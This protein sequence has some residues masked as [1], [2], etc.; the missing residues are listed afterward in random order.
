MNDRVEQK[1]IDLYISNVDRIGEGMPMWF[2]GRRREWIDN[3]SLCALPDKR[4]ERYRLNDMKELF[5]ADWSCIF[6]ADQARS[7]ALDAME[8][9]PAQEL[10]IDGYKVDVNNGSVNGSTLEVLENGVIYG[11]LAVAAVDFEQIVKKYYNSIADNKADAVT[12]LNSSFM[13][14]GVFVYVPENVKAELPFVLNYY[15]GT[16]SEKLLNF[17]RTLIVLERGASAEIVV[18]QQ[19]CSSE[20]MLVDYVREIELGEGASLKLSEYCTM[21]ETS[22]IVL[23]SYTRQATNSASQGVL[24]MLG[25][26]LSR[27]NYTV[28]LL[29]AGADAKMY[30]LYLITDEQRA[31]I[32]VD[33]NHLVADCTSY[34][35]VKGVAA[36]HAVGSFTGRVY[37]APNAQRTE[38]FQQSRNLLLNDT[39]RIYTKPQLEIYADDVKCSHGATVGQLDAEAIYYMR[40]RGISEADARKLQMSGFVNDIIAHSP[41]ERLA[42]TVYN[43]VATKIDSL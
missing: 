14:D 38:A 22:N 2:N 8:S 20:N 40:Q 29:G 24:V 6:D 18:V 23:G 5:G 33:I 26:A 31:D 13:Q 1:L 42:A 39:A 16:K 28:D 10:P 19:G 30:G 7:I 21:S 15:Y 34:E 12:A 32:N 9:C 4:D 25:G 3:F 43:L 36:A 37:V 41:T 27:V 35:M 17:A 11:S